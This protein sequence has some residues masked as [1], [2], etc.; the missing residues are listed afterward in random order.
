MDS[1]NN[2][3]YS[4]ANTLSLLTD[5]FAL[6]FLFGIFFLAGFFGGSVWTENQALKLGAKTGTVATAPTAAAP[7]APAAP[8]AEQLKTIPAPSEKDHYRGNLNAKVALIEYSDFECPFCAQ[9]HPSMQQLMK[10]FGN[11]VVWIHRQYPL[12]FHP[13]AQPS[14]V[15]SECVAEQGGND[16]FWKFSDKIFEINNTNKAIT[17]ADITTA[18]EAS[19][20]NMATYNDCFKSTKF[21]SK[22]TQETAEATAAGVSGTPGTIILTKDGQAELIGGAVDY[23]TLKSMVEKYL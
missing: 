15:A 13:L 12:S 11:D 17:A 20:V 23:A 4:M 5:N 1:S 10:E 7:G 8:T 3:P 21:D 6:L 22:I 19:G 2:K 16:A 14:A 9:F 18:A